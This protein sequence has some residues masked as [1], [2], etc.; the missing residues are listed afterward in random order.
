[1]HLNRF[2]RL[3]IVLSAAFAAM[4]ADACWHSEVRAQGKLDA[5]YNFSL[6]GLPLGRGAWVI[7]IADDHFTAA[8]N[9]G[10]VGLAQIFASGQGQSAA[11]GSIAGG[12]PVPSTYSSSIA[13]DRKYDDVRMTISGGNVKEYVAEPP[14]MPSP[15]RVPLTEAHRRGVMDPMTAAL[16]RVPG[17]GNP[18]GAES[19]PRK[20]AIFDGRMRYDLHLMFKRL[21]NVKAE[22]GYHGPTAVCSVQFNPIAGH[23]PDRAAIKYLAGLRTIE[24]W[25]APIIG[26]RVLAPY[27]VTVPTPL[28]TGVMQATQF[29]SLAGRPNA[30]A[31]TQ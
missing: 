30:A 24:V 3:A 15:G 6:A 18:I 2:A 28:G 16:M 22:R 17:T 10:T 12:Q 29:V 26:T 27:R 8:A 1:V 7:D 21:E 11:R 20:L 25:L 31:K 23:I 14:S 9:G 19:C 13:T 5:R 4:L